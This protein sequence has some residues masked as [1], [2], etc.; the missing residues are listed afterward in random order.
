MII[1]GYHCVCCRRLSVSRFRTAECQ[2]YF[3]YGCIGCVQ[4][5][6]LYS[7]RTRKS[8]LFAPGSIFFDLLFGDFLWSGVERFSLHLLSPLLLGGCVFRSMDVIFSL[9]GC[10][11]RIS[12]VLWVGTFVGNLVDSGGQSLVVTS[13]MPPASPP[14]STAP[15]SPPLPPPLPPWF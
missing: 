13:L 1:Q 7:K 5:L 10:L 14:P 3:L 6:N 15:S 2:P 11:R 4:D 9:S 8:G 12:C